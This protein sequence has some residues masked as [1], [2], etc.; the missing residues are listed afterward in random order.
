VSQPPA[1][2][3]ARAWAQERW[4]GLA[5]VAMVVVAAIVRI[6]QT[7][8]LAAPVV[9]CD[10]FIYANLAK[11]LADH[12]QYLF[13]D[14]TLHQSLLYPLLLAPAWFADSMST[15]YALAKGITAAA[16]S[17][18][19]VPVYLWG[20]RLVPPAAAL[21]AAALTLLLPAF[22]FSEILMTEAVFLPTFLLAVFAIAYMLER[23][24]LLAQLAALGAIALAVSVRVQG[25]VLL[26]VI[27]TAVLIKLLFEVRAGA[28]RAELGAWLRRLW[29]T[30]ALLVGGTVLYVFYKLVVSSAPLSSGLG[31][32]SS[33]AQA[34]YPFGSTARWSVKHLAELGL[35]V[36]LVPMSSLIVLLW[37]GLRGA[38]T[39]SSERA[40]LS[41]VP[42]ALLWVLVE[43]GAFAATTTP[44]LFER[45][46]FYLEPLLLLAFVVWL[47]RG[48]PRPKV[49][50]AVALAVPALLLLSLMLAQ[51]VSPDSINGVSLSALY[52]FSIALPGGIHE[53]K[54]AIAVAAVLGAFLFAV[55]ARSIVVIALPLLLA[56]YFGVASTWLIDHTRNPD[57]RAIAGSDPSWVEHA[58]G[59]NQPVV[60]V[61]T[62]ELGP[63]ASV[64]MLQTEF[65]NPN[66]RH[67]YSVGAGDICE[68]PETP[69]TLNTATGRIAP[70]VPKGVR[71]ALVSSR[72]PF[73]GR[74][75]AAEGSGNSQLALYRIDRSLRVGTTTDG[76]YGDGWMGS[77]AQYSV[78]VSPGDRPGRMVVTLGRTGWGGPDV[79]GRVK[80]ALGRPAASGPGLAE[81]YGLRLWIV[82]RLDERT[83]VFAAR[84]PPLRVVVEVNPTF[85][86]SQFGLADTRQ[87]GA[88]VSFSFQAKR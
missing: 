57:G 41:V 88:Q 19:A 70:P 2:D 30:A 45:Y 33:L 63:D 61:N 31:P 36:G 13:R 50:T 44:A 42:A 78:F 3:R 87:L 26:L 34:H 82:H 59:R 71:Y 46:T 1:V 16:M 58:V 27:P 69:T 22:F 5:L 60:Y 84:R 8:G 53:L 51:I 55:C 68:L 80:I 76:V 39:T 7:R 81:V 9:L 75:I 77:Q 37:L 65:W 14:T 35:A 56:A 23:P 29:P 10:E 18:A 86:P 66:V 64:L 28:T 47:T 43:T 83:F 62:P 49:A 72:V 17:L 74:R 54:A 85:S 15:T 67:V 11:N 40:F 38:P 21:L 4:A 12:G 48:L 24:T 25:I 20:R 73:A 52:R 32:Y 6:V 79:P